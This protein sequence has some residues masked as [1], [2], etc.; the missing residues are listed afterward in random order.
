MVQLKGQTLDNKDEWTA[1]IQMLILE[2]MG[3]VDNKSTNFNIEY[4]ENF[5]FELGKTIAQHREESDRHN[6]TSDIVYDESFLHIFKMICTIF[7]GFK[8]IYISDK[9]I[10][11]FRKSRVRVG[12]SGEESRADQPL[13]PEETTPSGHRAKRRRS[14]FKNQEKRPD[15]DVN[16]RD[17]KLVIRA[18]QVDVDDFNE[19]A[20]ARGKTKKATLREMID[21]YRRHYNID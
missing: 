15:A 4:M 11:D 18:E 13:D 16:R 3:R 12:S 14:E 10:E 5:K 9:V 2:T 17:T 20:R 1:H 19:A 21:L 7:R 6:I 8:D